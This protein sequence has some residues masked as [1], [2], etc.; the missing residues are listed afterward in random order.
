MGTKPWDQWP[1]GWER[2][3]EGPG[4]AGGVLVWTDRAGQLTDPPLSQ[5][6]LVSRAQL[7]AGGA[8]GALAATL[9]AAGW[10]IRRFL[11]RRRLAAW[12]AEWLATGPRW[13][14]RR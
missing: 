13:S 7:A 5:T 2:G 11:D 8:V 10:I 1:F 3:A 9:V 6:E 4:E 12:D 14:S